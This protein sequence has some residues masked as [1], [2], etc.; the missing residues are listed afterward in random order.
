MARHSRLPL[1]GALSE[2]PLRISVAKLGHDPRSCI[3]RATTSYY[4]QFAARSFIATDGE[5]E[6][7]THRK[8]RKRARGESERRQATSKRRGRAQVRA[9]ARALRRSPHAHAGCA[10]CPPPPLA[11]AGVPPRRPPHVLGPARA[12]HQRRRLTRQ[13]RAPGVAS[14]LVGMRCRRAALP[15]AHARRRASRHKTTDCN[16]RG[17]HAAATRCAPAHARPNSHTGGADVEATCVTNDGGDRRRRTAQAFVNRRGSV[18]VGHR[19]GCVPGTHPTS[20]Q[21]TR[22]CHPECTQRIRRGISGSNAW[23][24]RSAAKNV[25]A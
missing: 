9:P 7:R 1:L 2:E 17:P 22:R 11:Q 4:C 16:A 25:G 19:S 6:L 21:L 24:R 14:P 23:P 18:L 12:R 8:R 3:R 13:Q 10:G 15:P 5:A 20:T